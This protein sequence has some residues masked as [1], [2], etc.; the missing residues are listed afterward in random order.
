MPIAILRSRVSSLLLCACSCTCRSPTLGVSGLYKYF[1][2]RVICA[3]AVATVLCA[4]GL[5]GF[6]CFSV[7]PRKVERTEQVLQR[8]DSMLDKA[9]AAAGLDIEYAVCSWMV[10]PLL[11]LK[12]S[13]WAG[14]L[15]DKGHRL[16]RSA[17]EFRTLQQ[18]TIRQHIL[19][20]PASELRT[21]AGSG[22]GQQH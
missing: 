13:V 2:E 20:S 14:C 9:N 15:K 5:R 17:Q 16:P 4:S 10:L 19:E 7:V 6:G 12:P 8:F 3:I 18:R 1:V 11:R 21:H 22:G